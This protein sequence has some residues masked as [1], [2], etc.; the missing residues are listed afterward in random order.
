MRGRLCTVSL[1]LLIATR[2]D[3][4]FCFFYILRDCECVFVF[5]FV[6]REFMDTVFY[7]MG[8]FSWAGLLLVSPWDTYCV[9]SCFV[10]V[11]FFFCCGSALP[12]VYLVYC[13]GGSERF[14]WFRI[15]KRKTSFC[16]L[17]VAVVAL[18]NGKQKLLRGRRRRPGRTDAKRRWLLRLFGSRCT[19]TTDDD[20]CSESALFFFCFAGLRPDHCIDT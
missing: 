20:R 7:G 17:R 13:C 15:E 3:L 11:L 19:T 16:V 9:C 2:S 14:A 18:R 1:V 8:D 5:A 10:F 12:E 6:K 4:F